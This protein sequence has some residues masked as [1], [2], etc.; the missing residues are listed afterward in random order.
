MVCEIP[1]LIP[2]PAQSLKWEL[3]HR[4]F[5]REPLLAV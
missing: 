1:G 2:G 3:L 4:F 5:D